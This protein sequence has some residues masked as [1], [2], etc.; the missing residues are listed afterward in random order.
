MTEAGEPEA[1]KNLK[2]CG[3]SPRKKH[4]EGKENAE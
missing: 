3:Q 2:Q 1:V 4:H